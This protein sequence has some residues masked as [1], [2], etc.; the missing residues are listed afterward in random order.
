MTT[1]QGPASSGARLLGDDYQHI[2]TW[3][4]AAQL[5]HSDPDVTRVEM[6][7]RGAGNVDDLVVRRA[8]GAE[9]YHQVKFVRNPGKEPLDA[10]WL[11]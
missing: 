4:H 1:G 6:E 10:D 5:V 11:S 9:Q 8:S 2:L 3:L 7:K